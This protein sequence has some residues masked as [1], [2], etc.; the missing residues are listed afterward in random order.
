MIL[1][2]INIPFEPTN[3]GKKRYTSREGEGGRGIVGRA[4]EGVRGGLGGR[5]SGL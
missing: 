4:R 5:E 3:H 2:P 1:P